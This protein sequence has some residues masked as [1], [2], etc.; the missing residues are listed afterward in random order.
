[1]RPGLSDRVETQKAHSRARRVLLCLCRR[2]IPMMPD[3]LRL[4]PPLAWSLG[5]RSFKR[6]YRTKAVVESEGSFVG[7]RTSIGARN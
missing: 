6:F 2:L 4:F 3:I 5:L 7:E 1:M